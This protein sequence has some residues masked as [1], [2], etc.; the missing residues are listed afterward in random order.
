MDGTTPT[1]PNE[2]SPR[3]QGNPNPAA[4][5]LT[6]TPVS[7]V[8]RQRL[9]AAG[10][11]NPYQ[12]ATYSL[13]PSALS[14]ELNVTF[15]GRR[16]CSGRQMLFWKGTYPPGS[17]RHA[18]QQLV[19][20]AQ[21]GHNRPD[22]PKAPSAQPQVQLPGQSLL[23]QQPKDQMKFHIG[24]A[25]EERQERK[26]VKYDEKRQNKKVLQQQ[27]QQSQQSPHQPEEQPKQQMQ[28]EQQPELPLEDYESSLAWF[29]DSF[30]QGTDAIRP[31][32][33]DRFFDAMGESDYTQREQEIQAFNQIMIPSGLNPTQHAPE[34]WGSR[35]EMA[36]DDVFDQQMMEDGVPYG[37]YTSLLRGHGHPMGSRD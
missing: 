15:Q 29:S 11:T 7:P 27:Q 19:A 5:G 1:P 36:F 18:T 10:Y 14:K 23:H 6:P 13:A 24:I 12:Y 8:A 9:L 35:P 26:R 3:G 30:H 20:N 21:Q 25:E 31:E 34:S 22:R 17:R 33:I 32:E 4:Q 2:A 28:P 37:P 16:E